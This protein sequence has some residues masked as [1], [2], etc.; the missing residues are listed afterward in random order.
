MPQKMK[1]VKDGK[2]AKKN[3]YANFPKAIIINTITIYGHNMYFHANRFYMVFF[4]FLF[5]F[6]FFF[7]F[8]SVAYFFSFGS[9]FQLSSSLLAKSFWSAQFLTNP[10]YIV[11]PKVGILFL[12]CGLLKPFNQLKL[13]NINNLIDN[14]TRV[15]PTRI[16]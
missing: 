3:N 16:V 8:F 1:T 2:D 9:F 4:W 14:Y 12:D 10:W 15:S 13:Q 6:L 7:S 11:L 5:F